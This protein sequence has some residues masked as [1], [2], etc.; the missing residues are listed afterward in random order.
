MTVT[1]PVSGVGSISAAC[2]SNPLE[3]K[4]LPAPV[5]TKISI[6]ADTIPDMRSGLAPVPRQGLAHRH[7][8]GSSR[9]PWNF[10]NPSHLLCVF[11]NQPWY[12]NFKAISTFFVLV[13]VSGTQTLLPLAIIWVTT[14]GI[15][16]QVFATLATCWFTTFGTFPLPQA[17]AFDSGL[18]WF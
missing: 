8:S 13:G 6:P 7:E 15:L 17:L 12:A 4:W 14:L 18:D 3:T 5:S 11:C 9:S 16:P 10:W 2:L 1:I